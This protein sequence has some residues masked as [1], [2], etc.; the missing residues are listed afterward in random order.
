MSTQ[1]VPDHAHR[2]STPAT[3]LQER[4]LSGFDKRDGKVAEEPTDT[5]GALGLSL[6][7]APSEPLIDFVFV[8]GLR[9]GSRKTW[10]LSKDIKHFWPRQWLPSEPSFRHVRIHSF[11]YNSDWS[12]W[13]GSI[14]TVHD[15]GRQL[16]AELANSPDISGSHGDTAIVLV[17][18]SMGG[19]VIKKAVL[20]ARQDPSFY[21]LS[22]RIQSIFFLA[23]PHRGADSAQLLRKLL[24]V[25]GAKAYV[26]DLQPG[27][28]SIQ[29]LNDDF[30][31]AYQGIQ[32]WS[33][34]ETIST[35]IGL[36][37]D[38][39]SA[40]V[41]LPGERVQFLNAD[42]RYVCKFE[43]PQDDN[44]RT[45]RNAFSACIAAIERN[46]NAKAR[47]LHISGMQQLSQYLGD[48]GRPESD[49]A[50]I[51]QRQVEG[52][53]RWLTDRQGFRDWIEAQSSPRF[54]WLNGEP[55]SGK[56]TIAGHVIKTLESRSGDC[57]FFFFRHGDSKKSTIASLLCS[58]AWQ[59]ALIDVHVRQELL[60]MASEGYFL[61]KNDEISVWRSVFI[62]R[63]WKLT[64]HRPFYWIIDA[65]DECSNYHALFPLLIRIEKH[66]PLKVFVSSRPLVPV[67]RL[68]GQNKLERTL[69]TV[70]IAQ[71][72]KDIKLYLDQ[73]AEFLPVEDPSEK[74]RL[75]TEI[76]SRSNGNFLW[77][78]LVL[79]E[80][81]EP[82]SIEQVYET[83]NLVPNGMDGLYL[84]ILENMSKSRNVAIAKAILRWVICSM[85]PLTVD[86]LREALRLDIGATFPG[87]ETAI[88]SITE[89]LV[90][91]DRDFKIQ[92]AHLT[93]RAFLTQE[94]PTGLLKEFSIVPT[95]DH[96]RI[97]S[98]CIEYLKG[99]EMKS[100]RYRRESKSNL[101]NERSAFGHYAVD[102]FSDHLT[103]SEPEQSTL[104]QAVHIF[105]RSNALSWIECVSQKKDLMPIIRAS[106]NL[107]SYISKSPHSEGPMKEPV[108]AIAA[109][110]QDLIC[111]VA[112]FGQPLL[113][114]ASSIHFLIPPVCPSNSVLHKLFS[115]Y[116]KALRMSGLNDSEW[117]D[118][119]SC[120]SYSGA[121]AYSVTCKDFSF[122]VGLSN[123]TA[124][125]Y[126][127]STMQE[128]LSFDHTEHIRFTAFSN[129]DK[130]LATA[131]RRTIRVWSCSSGALLWERKLSG[132]VL[133]LNFDENGQK[134][135]AA[136]KPSYLLFLDAASGALT[137]SFQFSDIDETTGREHDRKR[138]PLHV[139]FSKELNLLAVAYRQRPIVIWDLEDFSFLGQY[140]KGVER[141]P[142]PLMFTFIFSPNP[143]TPLAA[144][145][146]DDGDIVVFDPFTQ[147]E[148][149]SV[150]AHTT[151]LRGSEDG[152]ILASG[153][154]RGQISLYEFQTLRLLYK[155]KTYELPI[156]SFAFS[157]DGLRLL[158]VRGDHCN[159]WQPTA[160]ARRYTS[161]HEIRPFNSIDG[162]L[163]RQQ[164]SKV[165][166]Y[167]DERTITALSMPYADDLVICG[168]EGGTL[169]IYSSSSGTVHKEL[170]SHD[171]GFEVNLVS[172]SNSGLLVASAHRVCQILVQKLTIHPENGALISQLVLD[173]NGCD[174]VKQLIISH[175]DEYLLVSMIR[176][177]EIWHIPSGNVVSI[178]EKTKN[179]QNWKWI[180]SK[181]DLNDLFLVVDGTV[182]RHTWDNILDKESTDL[183]LGKS[184]S[185]KLIDV[186]QSLYQEHHQICIILAGSR[187]NSLAPILRIWSANSITSSKKDQVQPVSTYDQ[188]AQDLKFVIGIHKESLVYLTHTGWVCSIRLTGSQETYYTRH[189][190][191]PFRYHN[192]A[193]S[194]LMQVTPKGNIVMSYRRDLIV[195]A[196][197]LNFEEKISMTGETL[198]SR[199]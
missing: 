79:R 132:V 123:G 112:S 150:D 46:R 50:R 102:Y 131:S 2:E 41:G 7:Y 69:E 168:R 20:L 94:C 180:V 174:V 96:L 13:R 187:H 18:H 195:F 76:L 33:F 55:A 90:Y 40:I 109:W 119:M 27:S 19:L 10:S 60:A 165:R 17:G 87:F 103:K 198:S 193:N 113:T 66:H 107:H 153:D 154:H 31:N 106:K 122:A 148:I 104:L 11:G 68:F 98:V 32:L 25:T 74:E 28:A 72:L 135:V 159:I 5:R 151:V 62:A 184:K 36:I 88:G 126:D 134:V 43:S 143:D 114:S 105:M 139:V 59:M 16:L 78:S 160:L 29:L 158:D 177:D 51:A 157:D 144:T 97:C 77:A 15:F 120:I 82:T 49:L 81:A 101:A 86:E 188:I 146:Y 48:N 118:R 176:K 39:E 71:S 3:S 80:L 14:L 175:D 130:I 6:L 125:V 178:N 4:P 141:F 169:A 70:S 183:V 95:W 44:Y 38:R 67:D 23:T 30:K 85:R 145:S 58:L 9:G 192:N 156:R 163:T 147:I 91:V 100:L 84:R 185:C 128:K 73:N 26:K 155:I 110:A 54:F 127:I 164:V 138:E 93:V 12:E 171:Q 89:Q 53:C 149:A 42:H 52:S 111:L 191:I 99:P 196:N 24:A 121:Q 140:K 116:P 1:N 137:G 63:I 186:V 194:L 173:K 182:Q 172:I 152:S 170:E 34:F 167:E 61:D 162:G 129:T 75:L 117:D 136:T 179:R 124:R 197:G 166:I 142:W 22:G 45:L 189:F 190:F 108:Q 83:L 181:L 47:A 37:V 64:F 65:L 133:S 56:S 57:A 35:P 92:L 21:A 115:S 161:E 199:S 8:H